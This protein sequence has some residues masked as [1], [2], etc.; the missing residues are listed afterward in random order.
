MKWASLQPNR[1]LS[2]EAEGEFEDLF[3]LSE[4]HPKSWAI[5]ADKIYQS[6]SEMLRTV[7]PI[8]KPPR[9]VLSVDDGEL[10]WN[11]SSER[12]VEQLQSQ[13]PTLVCYSS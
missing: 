2:R 11:L 13:G 6:A 8:K 9:V 10:K 7:T 12:D 4:T 3:L 1:L 5:L